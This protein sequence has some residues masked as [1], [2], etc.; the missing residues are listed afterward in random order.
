[1]IKI[2]TELQHIMKKIK[3]FFALMVMLG[4]CISNAEN[5]YGENYNKIPK[6]GM[7]TWKIIDKDGRH[8]AGFTAYD[9]NKNIVIRHK[10]VDS[11]IDDASCFVACATDLSLF[12]VEVRFQRYIIPE[13]VEYNLSEIKCCGCR[14]TW[15]RVHGEI[16]IHE[17][18]HY[19]VIKQWNKDVVGTSLYTHAKNLVVRETGSSYKNA[20]SEAVRNFER[21]AVDL[22][23][24]FQASHN[25]KQEEFHRLHGKDVQ[26]SGYITCACGGWEHEATC[27]GKCLK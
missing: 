1:M 14:T 18:G 22:K 9:D 19:N 24:K 7:P 15:K 5:I 26:F 2:K 12:K 17:Q 20:L 10:I 21:K 3:I 23:Q 13:W 8:F 4:A 16:V 27:N 11:G 25:V 6:P